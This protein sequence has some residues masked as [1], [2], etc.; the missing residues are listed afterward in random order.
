MSTT[1]AQPKLKRKS[2]MLNLFVSPKEINRL[3]AD[4]QLRQ[5]RRKPP[6]TT[7]P[8][9]AAPAAPDPTPSAPPA[10]PTP[11]AP[12]AA[13]PTPP[14]PWTTAEDIAIL[15]LKGSGK[16]FAEIATS[17]AP[18][19]EPEVETR[20]KEIGLPATITTAGE[21]EPTTD[22]PAIVTNPEPSKSPT[23]PTNE[24]KTKPPKGGGGGGKPR[25]E[26]TNKQNAKKG[27]TKPAEPA[28][29][30]TPPS[31]SNLPF[32]DPTFP[33]SSAN[34]APT[35]A[36]LATSHDRKI[37]GILKRGM[38]GAYP[39]TTEAETSNTIPAGA[40]SV[41]GR[42]I[43]YIEENDPL[44]VEELSTL[45]HMHMGFEEQ[46]WIRMASKFFDQTGKRIEP[47]WLKAK[48]GGCRL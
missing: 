37:Q 48:L 33:P 7:I 16:T 46:R 41:N 15:H 20:F 23:P 14:T 24:P 31:S 39:T 35:E 43:I 34:G 38:P 26:S 25:N 18:R 45:Y 42:P 32:T 22:T 47:E 17:L 19:T 12:P 5:N 8:E 40:T 1:T 3:K 2:A 21:P 30:T 6:T 4:L 44:G 13:E 10:D 9:P 36:I 28:P 11:S 27:K 29:T